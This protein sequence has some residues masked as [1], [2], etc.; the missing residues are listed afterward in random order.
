MPITLWDQ[1]YGVR[2]WSNWQGLTWGFM[3]TSGPTW[4]GVQDVVWVNI[5]T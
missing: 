4:E 1:S 5:L 2:M 3:L